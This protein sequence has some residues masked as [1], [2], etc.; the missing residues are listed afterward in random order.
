M[1]YV[2]YTHCSGSSDKF[3]LDTSVTEFTQTHIVYICRVW[4]T[5]IKWSTCNPFWNGFQYWLTLYVLLCLKLAS[6]DHKPDEAGRNLTLFVV[7]I[8]FFFPSAEVSVLSCNVSTN[9]CWMFVPSL[10]CSAVCLDPVQPV[11]PAGPPLLTPPVSPLYRQPSTIVVSS[12]FMF[13]SSHYHQYTV[14]LDDKTVTM[15]IAK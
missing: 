10:C 7:F 6:S 1:K 5:G 2:P 15:Y 3:Y 11:Y 9:V 4:R 14:G 13:V 12:F 8:R